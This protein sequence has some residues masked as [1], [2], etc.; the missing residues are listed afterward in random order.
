MSDQRTSTTE[1]K[2]AEVVDRGDSPSAPPTVQYAPVRSNLQRI[3]SGLLGGAMLVGSHI[4]A[5][6]ASLALL[7]VVPLVLFII[8]F[9]ILFIIAST[10]GRN[11]G[12]PVA[13]PIG[14]GL[15]IVYGLAMTAI[16]CA[17][18]VLFD[19]VR[20]LLH[21]P[22]WI[23]PAAVVALSFT[24]LTAFDILHDRQPFPPAIRNALLPTLALTALF[25]VYWIPLTFTAVLVRLLNWTSKNTWH[26]FR[27][28]K[29]RAD[30][31][32]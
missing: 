28:K 6:C 32:K 3:F 24:L 21:W 25:C 26:A 9:V 16:A 1:A 20:R 10:T 7:V 4:I 11:L 5:L 31:I 18:N 2:V 15:I 29:M 13:F 19:T 27:R 17:A 8:V 22:L 23:P 30:I 14:A 12:S